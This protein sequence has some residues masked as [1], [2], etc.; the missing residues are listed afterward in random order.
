M[1]SETIKL[2][3]FFSNSN[4]KKIDAEDI[5]INDQIKAAFED[6]F[7]KYA[8]SCY[9]QLQHY[10]ENPL[11]QMLLYEKTITTAKAER[12]ADEIF[13]E[14]LT[15]VKD[16]TNK[17]YFSLVL[18]FILLFRECLNLSMSKK[19][20]PYEDK[21]EFSQYGNT[22]SLPELCNEFVADFLEPSNYFG[23]ESESDRCELIELIQHFCYWL[24][25]NDY[26]KSKLTLSNGEA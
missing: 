16:S 3:N 12:N 10:T 22:E 21:K 13:Y 24:F 15:I 11:L 7:V 25:K 8:S 17:S 2:E 19:E 14:Y 20:V 26:T 4:R 9:M 5:N 23:I 18:K 6:I 1:E